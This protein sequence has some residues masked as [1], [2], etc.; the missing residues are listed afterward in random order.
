[1]KSYLPPPPLPAA[2]RALFWCVAATVFAER[3]AKQIANLRVAKQS[4][5]VEPVV[6]RATGSFALAPCLRESA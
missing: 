3:I 6:S 4:V 1:L 5:G 2:A